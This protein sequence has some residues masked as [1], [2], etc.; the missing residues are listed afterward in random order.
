VG[1]NRSPDRGRSLRWY[2]GRV[3][4]LSIIGAGPCGLAC[5]RELER[6]GFADW[7]VFEQNPWPGGHASSVIDPEGFTWDLGGHVVFSHFG[8]FDSLLRDVL[9]DEVYEHER[10]SYIRS[11]DRWVPYPFQN[12]LRYLEPEVVYECLL[13]LLDARGG[14][15]DMDFA[16]WMEATFGPGITRHF[17]RPYNL[18]VW[19]TAPEHMSATWIGDRVSVVDYKRAL[20][21]VVLRRDDRGWGPNSTFAFPKR[22]GTGE[23]YRRLAGRLGARVHFEHELIGIDPDQ[24]ELRFADGSIQGYDVL[25]S[26]MPLDRL[27]ALVSDCPSEVL[28]AARELRYTGVA[29]VG[30]GYEQ[31]L[32]SETCWMYFPGGE[33]PFYRVTNFAKYSPANVPGG[34]VT[35]YSSYLTECAFEPAEPPPRGDLESGVV[36][37]LS[38]AGIVQDRPRVASVHRI[39]VDYAYPV[40]TLGRDRALRTIQPWL[41]ERRI[42]SRGRFGSWRYEMGNMDHAVK[43]GIDVARHVAE[44]RP[45][46]LWTL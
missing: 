34:D 9:G 15:G 10:S 17:M 40:P 2:G 7:H 44:G 32:G 21:N 39:D 36:E 5:A 37:A 4:R 1:E 12:N 23:I 16:T 18:K 29:V 28:D 46:E 24:N 8:E 41:M 11:G 20:A 3:E 14:S 35:R 33:T 26:T 45:E 6:L 38:A 13:G 30:V 42:Y 19:M 31:P 43:M 25:V 27:V 22:G